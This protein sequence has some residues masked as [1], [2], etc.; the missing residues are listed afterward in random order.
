M[1]IGLQGIILAA[2]S[3]RS[4]L[5]SE[6]LRQLRERFAPRLAQRERQLSTVLSNIPQGVCLFDSSQ[7]LVVCNESYLKMYNLSPDVARSLLL[8]IAP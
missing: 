2:R 1:P 8:L 3:L 4:A 7:R 6:P 5:N